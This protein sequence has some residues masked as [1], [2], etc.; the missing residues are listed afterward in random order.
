MAN[1]DMVV[2]AAVARKGGSG[3]SSLIKTLASAALA[4]RKTALL[5]DTDAQGD[6]TRWYARAA[7]EGNAPKGTELATVTSTR[8]LE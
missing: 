5:I 1:D 6:L 3:K 7:K 4:A 8:Q 2:V